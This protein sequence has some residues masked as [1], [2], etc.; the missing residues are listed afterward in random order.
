MRR[1][2]I[3]GQHHAHSLWGSTPVAALIGLSVMTLGVVLALI[4]PSCGMAPS[5]TPPP[6]GYVWT[7]ATDLVYLTWSN[8]NGQ[9]AGTSTSVSYGDTTF[10]NSTAP[11]VFTVGYSG[12]QAGTTVQLMLHSLVGVTLTGT[13]SS[14][15]QILTLAVSDE[16]SG[17]VTK[18]TWVAVT[19]Q[20]EAALLAAF[21]ANEVER[22][23][24]P[25]VEQD[26]SGEPSPWT[27]QNSSFIAQ[28]QS[29]VQAD[30]QM[31]QTIQQ[32]HDETIQC[33]DVQTFQAS[34][35]L[36]ATVFAFTFAPA[37]AALIHH[38]LTLA[39]AWKQVQQHPIP[40]IAGLPAAKLSWVVSP[41][42]YQAG[43]RTAMHIAAQIA[44]SKRADTAQLQALLRQYQRIMQTEQA[45]A[46]SCPGT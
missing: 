2:H 11:A 43:T 3:A 28:I 33:Q 6:S 25:V 44:R 37:D 5:P 32:A 22:G 45:I 29:E 17:Q 46:K 26:A 31:L 21:N 18:Q 34:N 41:A 7:D 24:L 39:Q 14:D 10:A 19:P 36:S 38:L 15:G 12:M 23:M 9:L 20:Q 16:Q 30:Q 1:Q 13:Q 42:Q 4:F 35:L 40:Y 27:D 8:Q